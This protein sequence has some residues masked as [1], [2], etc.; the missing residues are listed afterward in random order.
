MN[1]ST[2]F[3]KD[4]LEVAKMTSLTRLV[5]RCGYEVQ[6]F[7]RHHKIKGKKGTA[8]DLSSLI[9]FNDRT[10]CRYADNTSGDQIGFLMTFGNLTMPE[11]VKYIC[12]L[13]GYTKNLSSYS[14]NEKMQFMRT[15]EQEHQNQIEKEKKP[16]ELP[17]KNEN[18]KRLF[19]YLNQTR[20]ISSQCIQYFLKK[21]IMY[22]EKNHHNIVFCGNDVNGNTKFASMRGTCDYTGRVFKCD[23]TGNDKFYGFNVSNPNSDT[24]YVFEGAIDLISYTD[25]YNDYDSNKLALGMTADLPLERFLEE[26]P[27]IKKIVLSLDN[28]KAGR[29]GEEKILS[30]YGEDYEIVQMHPI[31]GKDWNEFLKLQKESK[32]I[33]LKEEPDISQL[34]PIQQKKSTFIKI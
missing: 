15:K 17:E 9:I 22:E 23:V 27:H 5:E 4:E 24:L 19:A 33:N 18:N 25:I 8:G 31:E 14:K 3:T 1:N 20:C 29:L 7:G 32:L 13:E 28:D 30:K 6:R 26:H 10:W 12:E 2:F 34:K 21:H 16:F 11:A